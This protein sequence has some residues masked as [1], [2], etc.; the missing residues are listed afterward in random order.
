MRN[1]L[2]YLVNNLQYYLQVVVIE[3]QFAVLKKSVENAKNVEDIIKL[4]AEFLGNLISRTFL[5]SID[6]VSHQFLIIIP[7]STVFFF[8]KRM[9]ILATRYTGYQRL[10]TMLLILF[11]KHYYFYYN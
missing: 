11:I 4:H 1:S 6:D 10:I 5:M 3:A 9:K 8:R 2:L 7:F